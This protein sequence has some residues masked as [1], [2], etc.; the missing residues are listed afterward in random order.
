M[1]SRRDFMLGLFIIV[2]GVVI[3]LGK[4]GFFGF[5]G[6]TLWPLVLLLPGILI[7][8]LFF[9]RRVSAA[10]LIPG[11]ILTVYGLLFLICSLGGWGLMSA[12][13]PVL[14]LGVAAGL[15]EYYLFETPRPARV[16][17]L[18]LGIALIG[19]L[20]WIFTWLQAGALYVIA[21]V[22]IAIGVWLIF[23]RNRSKRDKWSR[24]W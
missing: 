24:G 22:L 5:V 17:P 23:G 18:A 20:I 14:I 12:L 10:F 1:S 7:H 3:L 13:W 15:Y 16:L 21:L 6:R 2:A 19:V 4:L 8:L 9:A 11:G